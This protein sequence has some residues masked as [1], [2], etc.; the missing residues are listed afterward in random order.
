MNHIDLLKYYELI[1]EYYGNQTAQRSGVPLINHI[2]EGL[3]I[4]HNELASVYTKAAFCIH[5]MLQSDSA[6]FA[7]RR[8][9]FDLDS[10]VIALAM[11][12]RNIANASLS[13]I[14]E[15]TIEGGG[16]MGE[17]R[18]THLKRSIKLSPIY[19]VNQM[20]IADKVQNRKDFELYHKKT[21]E[22]RVELDFYFKSWLEA[23]KITEDRYKELL[24]VIS[25]T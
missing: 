16:L 10:G 7:N 4:L 9:L 25:N 19:G 24:G 22:R 11:E 3:K 18:D 8:M 17:Y 23:L 5:P 6:L 12:Y 15:T 21:H 13:D 2:D 20:L 14:V 1:A